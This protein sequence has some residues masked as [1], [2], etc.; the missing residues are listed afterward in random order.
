MKAYESMTK[1]LIPT[2]LYI[3]SP[4]KVLSS[5]LLSYSCGIDSL[6]KSIDEV[7]KEA[8]ISTAEDLGLS[9]WE[10]ILGAVNSGERTEKRRE[11]I[12]KRLMLSTK[13]FTVSGINEVIG[14]LGITDYTIEENPSQ[15][16]VTVDLSRKKY[17]SVQ[18]AWIQEQLNE[19]FPA[20]LEVC[21]IFGNI[22][23]N[24]IDAL[25]LTANQMDNAKYS[26]NDIDMMEKK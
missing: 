13:S 15:F 6:D 3:I 1:K 22:T 21:A 7:I 25:S 10:D 5:E 14:S 19:L 16:F 23:W 9:V 11:I 12:K 2:G 4:G 8:F 24:D 17:S 18:K 26:W 20:H